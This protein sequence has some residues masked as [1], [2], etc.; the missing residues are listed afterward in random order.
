MRSKHIRTTTPAPTPRGRIPPGGLRSRPQQAGAE[1]PGPGRTSKSRRPG[2]CQRS[3][4]GAR[5]SGGDSPFDQPLPDAE[6][7]ALQLGGAAPVLLQDTRRR[8]RVTPAAAGRLPGAAPAPL[9][10]SPCSAARYSPATI[11]LCSSRN[12]ASSAI[13]AP[14]RG[15]RQ[16]PAVR[17]RPAP[18]G[19][20][21]SAAGAPTQVAAVGLVLAGGKPRSVPARRRPG[22]DCGSS[23]PPARASPGAEKGLWCYRFQRPLRRRWREWERHKRAPSGGRRGAQ[24]WGQAFPAELRTPR[25]TA[26]IGRGGA[27]LTPE[28]HSLIAWRWARRSLHTRVARA[29]RRRRAQP[30]SR[31]RGNSRQRSFTAGPRGTARAA[32][33]DHR[34]DPATPPLPARRPARQPPVTSQLTGSPG[35]AASVVEL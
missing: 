23:P 26:K 2:S 17:R 15:S 6:A 29:A 20:G 28:R 27:V 22:K 8:R 7:H 24:R 10:P 34:E 3:A 33:R 5:G 21:L 12:S 31:C 4:A 1:G 30:N 9:T 35:A 18:S 13:S 25:C 14:Q 16:R 32:A 11:S 19:P